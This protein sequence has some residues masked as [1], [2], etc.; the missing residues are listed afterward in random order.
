MPA[1]ISGHIGRR[2]LEI[3]NFKHQILWPV[4]VDCIEMLKRQQKNPSRKKC[5]AIAV[6]VNRAFGSGSVQETCFKN[7]WL[8]LLLVEA[9][10][11][12]TSSRGVTCQ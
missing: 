3:L 10:K 7:V 11:Y 12:G 6:T 1:W 5:R 9:Y 2:S 8:L 4:F